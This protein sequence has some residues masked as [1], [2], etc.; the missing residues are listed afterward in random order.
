MNF[1]TDKCKVMHFEDKNIRYDYKL[2]GN[3]LTK[4]NE[5]KDFRV[6]ISNNLKYA[7]QCQAASKKGNQKLSFISRN[8]D[9]KTPET[10]LALNISLVRPYLE[11]AVQFWSPKL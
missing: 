1:E 7:K 3:S 2:F 11:H 5:E 10:I 9:Y 8:I 6:V 4:V